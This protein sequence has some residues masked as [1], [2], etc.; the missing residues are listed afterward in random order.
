MTGSVPV[1]LSESE[2]KSILTLTERFTWSVARPIIASLGLP[3][4]RGREATNEKILE[5]LI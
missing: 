2:L 5:S 1:V 3:T 4:G